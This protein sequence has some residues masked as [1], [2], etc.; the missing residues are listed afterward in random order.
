MLPLLPPLTSFSAA[1]KQDIDKL[2]DLLWDMLN[3]EPEEEES[4]E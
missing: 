1:T 4:G 3:P 2:K